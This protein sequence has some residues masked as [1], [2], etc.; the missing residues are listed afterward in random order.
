LLSGTDFTGP[1]NFHLTSS[2]G[3]SLIATDFP[4][5]LRTLLSETQVSIRVSLILFPHFQKRSLSN[6]ASGII[7]QRVTIHPPVTQSST[8]TEPRRPDLKVMVCCQ[9]IGTNELASVDIRVRGSW[10]VLLM[11]SNCSVKLSRKMLSKI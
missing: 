1:T 3:D 5:F 2:V 4:D 6:R 7:S 11:N 9:Q 8:S 10:M